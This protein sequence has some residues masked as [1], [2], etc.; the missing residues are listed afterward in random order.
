[1]LGSAKGSE[2][3]RR[4]HPAQGRWRK[5]G[6]R[7]EATPTEAQRTAGPTA[8][9]TDRS[10][11]RPDARST[12]KA[13][14]DNLLPYVTSGSLAISVTHR[15]RDDAPAPQGPAIVPRGAKTWSGPPLP[16]RRARRSP[17]AAEDGCS[18]NHLGMGAARLHRNSSRRRS[19]TTTLGLGGVKAKSGEGKHRHE[20]VAKT[21]GQ[22]GRST[23]FLL[24]GCVKEILCCPK[25]TPLRRGDCRLTPVTTE[26]IS[27]RHAGGANVLPL[28]SP[29]LGEQ[30]SHGHGAPSSELGEQGRAEKDPATAPPKPSRA[31]CGGQKWAR[32]TTR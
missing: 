31:S 18:N 2:L 9:P 12:V 26:T 22:L 17:T 29:E 11:A 15:P 14:T 10:P 7:G 20:G 8:P 28:P 5:C 19:H 16:K 27:T 30:G 6:F 23:G 32:R 4:P 3:E 13:M 21:C 1:M 25:F 24:A